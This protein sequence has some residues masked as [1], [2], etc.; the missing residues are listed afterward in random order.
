M[1][2]IGCKETRMR[3]RDQWKAVIGIEAGLTGLEPGLEQWGR[4]GGVGEE[5]QAENR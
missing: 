4:G 3:M 2:V 5:R 1:A